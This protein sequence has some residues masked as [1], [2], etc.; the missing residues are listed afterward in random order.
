[1][2]LAFAGSRRPLIPLIIAG[3]A[4]F[5]IAEVLLGLSRSAEP[6]FGLVIL[7]GLSSMLMINTIN[8]T[9]QFNVPDA[10]RGRVMSLYVL[11]FAG[12][13]PLGGLFAGGT[14]QLF[15]APAGFIVGG[16]L[17]A[18]FLLVVAWQLITRVT[19]PSLAH[20]DRP[21]GADAAPSPT[22]DLTAAPAR[23]GRTESAGR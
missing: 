9:I 4:G 15:G 6:A 3:G 17:S 23:L 18:G 20:D 21:G 10:L 11:V 22:A 19:P 8:V 7:I 12:S 14:A 1:M 2:S 16:L 13:S 5:V